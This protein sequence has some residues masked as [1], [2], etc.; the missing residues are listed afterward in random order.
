MAFNYSVLSDASS[1]LRLL[2]ICLEFLEDN[3]DSA[4]PLALCLCSHDRA[5]LLHNLHTVSGENG[6]ES[7]ITFLCWDLQPHWGEFAISIRLEFHFYILTVLFFVFFIL[8]ADSGLVTAHY[9]T[10]GDHL[11]LQRLWTLLLFTVETKRIE[12]TFS[13]E[14]MIEKCNN[15]CEGLS[16]GVGGTLLVLVHMQTLVGVHAYTWSH[17]TC[18]GASSITLQDFSS[19]FN[20][21]VSVSLE[22]RWTVI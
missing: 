18:L 19:L 7:Q 8:S 3:K 1:A 21:V 9:P 2:I 11:S 12:D 14:G 5:L 10:E 6:T 22:I 13:S 17:E 16:V 20:G 4:C 15:V